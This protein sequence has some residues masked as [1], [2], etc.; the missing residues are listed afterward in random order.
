MDSNLELGFM[1]GKFSVSHSLGVVACSC[2]PVSRRLDR[3]D[4]L[5]W[6]V[7]LARL[8]SLTGRPI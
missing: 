8:C 4:G 5:S 2:N 7:L 1:Y 6:G 3:V